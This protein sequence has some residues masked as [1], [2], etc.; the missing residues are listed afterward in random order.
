MAEAKYLLTGG[1]WTYELFHMFLN[2]LAASDKPVLLEYVIF[3]QIIPLGC[4]TGTT[5]ALMMLNQQHSE[6]YF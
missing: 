6:P 4:N 1:Y 2:L 3:M 5:F